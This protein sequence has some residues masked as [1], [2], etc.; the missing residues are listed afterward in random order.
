MTIPSHIARSFDSVLSYMRKHAHDPIANELEVAIQQMNEFIELK[1]T[2]AGWKNSAEEIESLRRTINERDTSIKNL[3]SINEKLNEEIKAR[4]E[5]VNL[6]SV[7]KKR[8]EKAERDVND[9]R[10]DDGKNSDHI[11]SEGKGGWSV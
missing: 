7:L 8:L 11:H 9:L 10:R 5:I 2:K 3:L 1:S 6:Q 4:Q